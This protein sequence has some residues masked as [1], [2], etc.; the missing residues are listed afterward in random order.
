MK[1]SYIIYIIYIVSLS[2]GSLS[3]VDS[4]TYTTLHVKLVI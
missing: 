2:D 4:S 1:K 3:L